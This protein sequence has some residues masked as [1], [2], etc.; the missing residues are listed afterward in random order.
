MGID[1]YY[2]VYYSDLEIGLV[3][4]AASVR[5]CLQRVEMCVC[6]ALPQTYNIYIWNNNTDGEVRFYT[7]DAKNN[8]DY[9]KRLF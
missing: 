9:N 5:E 6:R 8:N 3:E 1:I 2:S 4:R 7:K